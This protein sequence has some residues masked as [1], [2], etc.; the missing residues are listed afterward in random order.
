MDLPTRMT[1]LSPDQHLAS[2]P[3]LRLVG[4]PAIGT[5]VRSES[6]DAFVD[7]WL[8]THDTSDHTQRSYA[9]DILDFRVC[10]GV[11]L[12]QLAVE[13]LNAYRDWLAAPKPHLGDKPYKEATRA[14]KIAAVKSMLS[15]AYD[16]GYMRFNVGKALPAPTVRNELAAR[17]LK[18]SL[19]QKIIVLEVD[20]RNHALIRLFYVSGGRVSEICGLKVKD[21]QE[22]EDKVKSIGQV[23]LFG[24]GGKTRAVKIHRELYEELRALAGDR[25]AQEA[26]ILS[27]RRSYRNQ[28]TSGHLSPV[29]AW[30][31][32]RIAALR[33]GISLPVSPHWLRH[34]HASHSLDRGA[35][36]HLVRDTLGHGSLLTTNRYLHARPDES[37][38]DYLDD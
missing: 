29:Q 3:A 34:A 16:T 37:S 28:P 11:E 20:P 14:R 10:V 13:D 17:I 12:R 35:P 32:I 5:W 7:A 36:P 6:D 2:V 18:K 22:R 9:K 1:T 15:F 24:K 27:R 26:L 38:S 19:I 25:D 8:K 23:T 33:A 30:R 4:A 21:L 31:I